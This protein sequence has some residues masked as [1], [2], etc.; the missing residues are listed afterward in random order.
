MIKLTVSD[1]E[2]R[3]LEDTFKTTTDRRLRARCQAILMAT[4]GRLHRHMAEDLGMSV[5]T[6]QRWLHAYQ[7]KPVAGLKIRW[8]P[9]RRP[10]IPEALAP[11]ILTWITRGPTGC[12][13]D[14][15]NWTY[16]ELAA[17]LYST[18]GIT[19]S[20]ST[21]RAFCTRHGV[22]PSRPTSHY[23]KA[24]SAQQE[25]ARQELQALKKKLTQVSSSC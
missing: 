22:R 25:T 23:L 13:L 3:Q 5:R 14:R 18:H 17:S 16:A 10:R 21:M 15:A 2:R 11:A 7:A 8:V 24:D 12:G 9:G 1:Q 19:V 4:R 20:A 6:I